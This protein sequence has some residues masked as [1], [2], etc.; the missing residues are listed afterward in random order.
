MSRGR[1]YFYKNSEQIWDLLVQWKTR[2]ASQVWK[3]SK[4]NVGILLQLLSPRGRG[5][6]K[7]LLVTTL[8]GITIVTLFQ[9]LGFDPLQNRLFK[10]ALYP[11]DTSQ[12]YL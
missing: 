10:R 12:I 8:S 6:P 11:S 3:G 7:L 9:P 5:L 1:G 2:L 4:S